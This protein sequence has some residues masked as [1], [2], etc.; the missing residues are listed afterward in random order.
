[1]QMNTV[2]TSDTTAIMPLGVDKMTRSV[3]IEMVRVTEAAAMASAKHQGSRCCASC[4]CR[5]CG[6]YLA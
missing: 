2:K 1:M 5:G 4:R 3:V 6:L